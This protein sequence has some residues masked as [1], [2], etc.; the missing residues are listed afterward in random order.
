M[1]R[2]NDENEERP[3]SFFRIEDALFIALFLQE[4]IN[5]NGLRKH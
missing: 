5:E 2:L 3:F 4:K 1:K